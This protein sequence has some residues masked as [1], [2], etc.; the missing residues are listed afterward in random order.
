[1]VNY[2]RDYTQGATYFFTLVLQNR[3]STYLTTYIDELGKAFRD[4]RAK[5]YFTT[6]AIIVLPDHLHTIWTLPEDNSDYSLRWRLIKTRFTQALINKKI[7]LIKN[8]RGDS[9]LWQKRFWEHRIRDEEDFQKH[10]DYIHYNPVKHGY[11]L[12][13]KDWPYSSIHRFIN[14]GIIP[15]DWSME[16]QSTLEE[17]E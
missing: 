16:Q 6:E 17:W 4:I 11:S 1:M 9:N 7:P 8:K 15:T 2:R 3:H 5:A 13:A 12:M 10:V 14:L